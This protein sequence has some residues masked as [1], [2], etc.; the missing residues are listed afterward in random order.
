[1][2]RLA[3]VRAKFL[4]Y[5]SLAGGILALSFSPVFVRWAE[6]PGPVT[7]FFRM[8]TAAL[9]LAPFALRLIV[10]ELKPRTGGFNS[11]RN[12]FLLGLLGGLLTA[13][14][15][16][17]WSTAL[18]S[19]SVANATLFNYIAPLWVALFAA[20]VWRERLRARF[21]LG[22]ALVLAGMAVVLG[23]GLGAGLDKTFHFNPGDVLAVVSS[24]FYA[25]YFLVAQRG[26]KRLPTLVFIWLVALG[27]ALG[28]LG[29]CLTLGMPLSG[30]PPMTYLAFLLA[31]LFSQIGGYFM[32]AYALGHLPAAVVA[33]TMIAQPV[34]SALLAIPIAG[35]LLSTG[36][37]LGGL[38][39]LA[40]IG[41]VNR[42][43]RT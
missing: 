38:A 30:Y 43:N 22:L 40:G 16:G 23:A 21:W 3:L 18:A 1:M 27:A 8:T 29:L 9:V 34:L 39:V 10:K 6:A 41:V 25:A 4:P 11:L 2:G 36:Q 20:L 26:R 19:T 28:L 12:P 5:L 37:V 17:F 31:G 15:H 42:E 35:E 32:V 14:D 24:F 33:P 7:S 13:G